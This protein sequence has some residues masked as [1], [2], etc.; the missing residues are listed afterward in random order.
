MN[1]PSRMRRILSDIARVSALVLILGAT[2]SALPSG[3]N[4]G[5]GAPEIDPGLASAGVALIVGG[6]LILTGRRVTRD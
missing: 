2:A 6:T 1:I 4:R 3:P 5:R